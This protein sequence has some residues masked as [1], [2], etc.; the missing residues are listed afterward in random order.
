MLQW[1]FR[2]SIAKVESISD[3]PAELKRLGR[4]SAFLTFSSFQP[5]VSNKQSKAEKKTVELMFN[6]SKG[7][8]DIF[9]YFVNY[10]ENIS[11]FS[12]AY[13]DY[14]D[15]SNKYGSSYEEALNDFL[16]QDYYIYDMVSDLH[17]QR[18]RELLQYLDEN[19]ID[20]FNLANVDDEQAISYT[21][22]FYQKHLSYEAIV[23]RKNKKSSSDDEDPDLKNSK[24]FKV[25]IKSIIFMVSLFVVLCLLSGLF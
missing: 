11:K 16:A 13:V 6:R 5:Y 21:L 10:N 24:I 2:K 14:F 15:M 12:I 22:A 18:F 8:K 19:K 9:Y 1:A 25:I 7:Y 3:I 4:V 23:S 17:L 20:I